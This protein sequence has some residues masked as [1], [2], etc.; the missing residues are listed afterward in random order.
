MKIGIDCRLG[1]I[2]HAGIGRYIAQLVAHLP[3][4][5]KKHQWVLF[6]FDEKQQRELLEDT[7]DNITW[8]TTAIP[9]YSIAEQVALKKVFNSE[10]LDL[11]HVPHFNAPVFYAGPTI[12]TIHDLL[13][14]QQWGSDVT[15]LP[16][17]KY[18]L[19]YLGYRYT[20]SRAI[21]HATNIITPSETTKQVLATYY[22]HAEKK[23]SV[24]LEGIAPAFTK[25]QQPSKRKLKQLVYVGSLYPH[26]NI[27]IVLQALQQLPEHNLVIVGS[28]N[29]FADDTKLLTHEL[30]VTSQV[31][32][33]GYVPDEKLCK[34]LVSSGALIQPSL[35]EGFG[36]T[37]VEALSTGTPVL[38]SD[39]AVF[40]EMYGSVATYF[41][42]HSVSELVDT[43]TRLTSPS[44]DW[45]QK[46]KRHVKQFDWEKMVQNT[47]QLY[48]TAH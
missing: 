37:G 44:K 38:A 10:K 40:K 12:I 42:P 33:A 26:K 35:S 3:T 23:T 47:I 36:L 45:L 15:T 25:K 28:R 8:R 34:L 21:D 20:A 18:W 9:H 5:G 31:T 48:E 13:W 14:H 1:G 22:P 6:S 43:I 11:L 46:A 2:A 16:G 27:R 41:D 24:V 29:V 19:K 17:W 4:Y 30:K 39:I 7:P 32:F